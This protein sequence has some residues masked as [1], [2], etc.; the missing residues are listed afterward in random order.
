[1][2]VLIAAAV[3]D[4]S[5]TA[6][7]MTSV[8]VP[9]FGTALLPVAVTVAQVDASVVHRVDYEADERPDGSVSAESAVAVKVQ[10][11]SGAFRPV[12]WSDDLRSTAREG[13][14]LL[15]WQG[16]SR[17]EPATGPEIDGEGLGE[18]DSEPSG[19]AV[20]PSASPETPMSSESI[21]ID[22]RAAELLSRLGV[23]TLADL[24]RAQPDRVARALR[25]DAATWLR[26]RGALL[27][28]APL[29]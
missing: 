4:E 8:A 2:S 20:D 27:A 22:A 15:L 12:R 10:L 9:V 17:V 11:A 3:A 6:A 1:M 21:R 29:D 25:I 18:P 28:F 23:E 16:N 24:V 7:P 14:V 19:V 5:S 26:Y 13:S